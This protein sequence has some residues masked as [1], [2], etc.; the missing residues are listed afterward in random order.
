[1]TEDPIEDLLPI[2]FNQGTKILCC[3]KNLKE[4]YIS[5]ENLKKGDLVKTYKHGYKKIDLIGKML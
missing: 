3:N 4:E 1:M 2:C 5:I